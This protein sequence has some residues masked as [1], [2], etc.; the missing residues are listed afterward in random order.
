MKVSLF[1][2]QISNFHFKNCIQ[3]VFFVAIQGRHSSYEASHAMAEEEHKEEEENDR[4][5]L[6]DRNE[7][8][9]RNGP[10]SACPNVSRGK[11]VNL[12]MAKEFARW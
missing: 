7:C 12:T 5:D 6:K 10:H 2:S 11:L 1:K 3:E 9:Q 4:Q 8:L